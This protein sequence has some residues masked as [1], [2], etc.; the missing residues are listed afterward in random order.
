MRTVEVQCLHRL[1]EPQD[2]ISVLPSEVLATIFEHAADENLFP[3]VIGGVCSQ[4]RNIA[5]ST[6]R[7]WTS[8]R[9]DIV[10]DEDGENIETLPFQSYEILELYFTNVGALLL[11]LEL[12]DCDVW[13]ACP[14]SLLRGPFI[15]YNKFFDLIFRLNP[16]K[17]GEF[18]FEELS[19][20]WWNVFQNSFQPSLLTKL[21]FIDVEWYSLPPSPTTNFAFDLSPAPSLTKVVLYNRQTIG[22][23]PLVRLPWTQL[24]SL[25]LW[26]IPVNECLDALLNKCPQLKEF[27]C[28]NVRNG[29]KP[30]SINDYPNTTLHSLEKLDW[31]I[32]DNKWTRFLLT[33][34][35]FPSL[36]RMY[37]RKES[38]LAPALRPFVNRFIQNSPH[39]TVIQDDSVSLTLE[40]F[41]Y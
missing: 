8:L 30:F 6:P 4:W 41:R 19:L 39:L 34:V 11:S 31:H 28:A 22:S 26:T 40:D 7:L 36:R 1:N 37:C 16:H 9:I 29:R 32:V 2:M 13:P 18:I 38:R 33:S 20:E 17:L 21:T 14:P 15:P 25:E 10:M 5:W 23:L 24:T 12:R 35:R 27:R 3:L